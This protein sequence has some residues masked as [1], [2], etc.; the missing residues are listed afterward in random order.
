MLLFRI[1]EIWK[2]IEIQHGSNLEVKVQLPQA[3]VKVE[4]MQWSQCNKPLQEKNDHGI[5][6]RARYWLRGVYVQLHD[7]THEQSGVTGTPINQ[8]RIS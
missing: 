6:I 3:P 2:L 4:S 1:K 7:W 5:V 8:T